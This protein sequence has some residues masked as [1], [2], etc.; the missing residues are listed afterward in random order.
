MNLTYIVHKLFILC[1][2]MSYIITVPVLSTLHFHTAICNHPFSNSV[3]IHNDQ[4][5]SKNH[6]PFCEV[7]FRI[8]STQAFF[9]HQLQFNTTLP[10]SAIVF[11]EGAEPHFS[12]NRAPTQG[13]APPVN[14]T[15]V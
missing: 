15:S 3:Q 5:S 9:H 8:N 7:C 6:V 2:V 4:A 1:V 10:A 13:R 11:S 12:I 14:H